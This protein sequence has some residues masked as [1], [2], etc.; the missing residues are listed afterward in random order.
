MRF[1]FVYR[2]VEERRNLAHSV[3]IAEYNSVQTVG[4]NEAPKIHGLT[5]FK[6]TNVA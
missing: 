1:P 3:T 4:L 6:P 2:S 5:F